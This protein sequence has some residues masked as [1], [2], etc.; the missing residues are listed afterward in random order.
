MRDVSKDGM[1]VVCEAVTDGVYLFAETF[2]ELKV[3]DN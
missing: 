2:V 3:R 1:Q